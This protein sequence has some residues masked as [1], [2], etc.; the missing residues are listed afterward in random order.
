MPQQV[1]KQT[2]AQ[3]KKENW[4]TTLLT[5][6][7]QNRTSSELPLFVNSLHCHIEKVVWSFASKLLTH[8]QSSLM[9]LPLRLWRFSVPEA[10]AGPFSAHE[11]WLRIELPQGRPFVL[12]VSPSCL[13]GLNFFSSS[14]I[15]NAVHRF[16]EDWEAIKDDVEI[17]RGFLSNFL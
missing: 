11:I 4:Y 8:A 15:C 10:V 6:C 14:A 2:N 9:K 3:T 17:C 1:F 5:R 13:A 12:L 7:Q 16:P